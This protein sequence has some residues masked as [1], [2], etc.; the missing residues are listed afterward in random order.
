MIR[1]PESLLISRE[2]LVAGARQQVP[3]RFAA[4]YDGYA[5]ALQHAPLND[6]TRRAYDSRVR[7]YLAWLDS[8]GITGPDP[9]TDP[10]GRDAAA[11]EYRDWLKAVANRQPA[12]ANAHLVA[13]DHFYE[14]VG[15]GPISRRRV[16]RDRLLRRP[17]VV[18]GERDRNRYLCAVDARPLPRD[19]AIGRLLFYSGLS[20]SELVALDTGDVPMSAR[21]N[22]GVVRLSGG[23]EI[24]LTDPAAPAALAEWQAE[25]TSWPGAD[26]RALFLNR[27]GGRLSARAVSQ[28][29]DDLAHDADI[30]GEDGRPAAFARVIRNTADAALASRRTSAPGRRP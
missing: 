15:L 5:V 25:R 1:T 13:L 23:R 8:A 14:H 28:L 10:R 30:T 11:I 4:V 26:T 20:V 21:K 22:K 27:H 2:A 24:P 3:E 18:L 7:S 29:V 6:D 16:R 9:L 12:T 17:P 19:R